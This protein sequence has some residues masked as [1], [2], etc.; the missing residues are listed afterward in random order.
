MS[1]LPA[2]RRRVAI[3]VTAKKEICQR[4]L[5]N[6]TATQSEGS[7]FALDRFGLSI[8][9]STISDILRD[10]AKWME[11]ED[12]NNTKKRTGYHEELEKALW[13]WFCNIRSRNLAVSDEMLQ[14]KGREFGQRL[15]V[16][17]GFSYSRGWLQG[18]KHRH[19]IS[20][21]TIQGE[22]ASVSDALV[23]EGWEK[24]LDDLA[25]Y[26]LCDIYNMDET[27]LFFRLQPSKT[28]ATGPVSGIKKCKQ[29]ITVALCANADGSHKLEPLV[30]GKSARPR[31]FPKT[32]DVQSVVNY[33]HNQKAW[34]TAIVF[35]QF[36]E[37]F[38]RLMCS[39]GRHVV[40]LLD[41]APSHRI[42]PELTNVKVVM[43]P[44]NTTSHIQPMDAGIIKNFKVHYKRNLVKHYV[45][46]IDEKGSSERLD[47]KQA[48]YF[49][50]DSWNAVTC[51]TITNCFRHF[52][53]I[54]TVN[55]PQ[56]VEVTEEQHL[57][58]DIDRMNLQSPLSAAEFVDVDTTEETEGPLT[59]DYI[60]Q[61]VQGDEE[62]DTEHE[63]SLDQLDTAHPPQVTLR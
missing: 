14:E 4:K 19:K 56:L 54:P 52:K 32:F 46:E 12:S 61:L 57:Q 23:T 8:G 28:L 10:S 43:L 41:N 37:K 58:A 25:G 31:C 5:K 35:Q 22:A 29:R 18:F 34:M 40:L 27:G 49:V 45:R 39:R 51:S 59:E 20:L 17:E 33:H 21:R 7:Q 60:L 44:F 50:K 30:I 2:K 62:G 11:E 15:G 9:R 26:E 3:S 1:T 38:D 48:I 16:S 47:L 36:L 63:D 24:L 53:I 6:P 42:P 55:S 13:L